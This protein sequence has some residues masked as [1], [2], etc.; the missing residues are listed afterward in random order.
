MPSKVI[1]LGTHHHKCE[2]HSH[3][4]LPG[5]PAGPGHSLINTLRKELAGER[6]F[7]WL[8]IRF[9]LL[10]GC[11]NTPLYHGLSPNEIIFFWATQLLVEITPEL[12]WIVQRCFAV[13]G[14]SPEG[15]QKSL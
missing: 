13:F 11:H 12:S 6:D 7:Q 9:A 10:C 5:K 4:A 14:R 3:R 8:V 2:I 1:R 15:T